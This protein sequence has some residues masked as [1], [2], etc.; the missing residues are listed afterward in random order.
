MFDGDNNNDDEPNYDT[1]SEFSALSDDDIEATND[2]SDSSSDDDDSEKYLDLSKIQFR[3]DSSDTDPQE[4]EDYVD[5]RFYTEHIEKKTAHAQTSSS[6]NL[7]PNLALNDL[8]SSCVAS[9][10]KPIKSPLQRRPHLY[11]KANQRLD[12]TL[13][14]NCPKII[15]K[16][17]SIVVSSFEEDFESSLEFAERGPQGTLKRGD[18]HNLI[19]LTDI[20]GESNIDFRFS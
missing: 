19:N 14:L 12:E 18:I 16:E 8:G 4:Y 3:Q 10:P 17:P 7:V 5:F 11:V 2:D 6:S 1:M 15:V 20:Q 9:T 13:P